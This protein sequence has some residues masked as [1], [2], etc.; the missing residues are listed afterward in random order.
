MVTKTNRFYIRLLSFALVLIIVPAVFLVMQTRK[1]RNAEMLL[2]GIYSNAFNEAIVNTELIS[3]SLQSGAYGGGLQEAANVW[4]AA[5]AVKASIDILPPTTED[6]EQIYT[7][8]SQVGDYAYLSALEAESGGEGA[9]PESIAALSVYT[10][11]FLEGLVSVA[12]RYDGGELP[13]GT[14][15]MDDTSDSVQ[16]QISGIITEEMQYPTLNYDGK[17]SSHMSKVKYAFIEGLK[18]I[19]GE[20]ALKKAADVL[21]VNTSSI[22]SEGESGGDTLKNY[23]F[24]AGDTSID[25][26]AAGGYPLL[27]FNGREVAGGSL[28]AKSAITSAKSYIEKCGFPNMKEYSYTENENVITVDFVFSQ[29]GAL[30]LSDKITVG[31]ARDNGDIISFSASEYIKNHSEKRTIASPVLSNSDASG[32]L[33]KGIKS[34]P[35]RL[36]VVMS[37]GGKESLCYEFL[38]SIE[39][40]SKSLC[41]IDA[42]TGR[43]KLTKPLA[44]KNLII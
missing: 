23:N 15:D 35:G 22:T 32:K 26:T 42:A 39:N 43:Q 27:M 44:Q 17:T 38:C 8:L 33:T 9:D 7:Y 30:V 40:G 41:Y 6:F 5:G 14:L 31:V 4:R 13:I 25:I 12:A 18:N 11:Q 34:N 20:D 37:D 1:L 24:S 16:S 28:D 19:T 2:S 36:V 10:D 29:N 3:T 21:G